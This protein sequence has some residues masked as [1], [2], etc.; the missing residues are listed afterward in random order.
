MPDYEVSLSV[1]ILGISFVSSARQVRPPCEQSPDD[2]IEIVN[3]GAPEQGNSCYDLKAP[4]RIRSFNDPAV[5]NFA[6]LMF[7]LILRVPG[8]T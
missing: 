2:G 1:S 7:E 3:V 6:A 8:R 5:L 4:Q